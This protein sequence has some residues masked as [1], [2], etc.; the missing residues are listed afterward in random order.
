MDDDFDGYT[1]FPVDY[2]C[3]GKADMDEV[4]GMPAPACGDLVDNDADGQLDYSRDP[5]CDTNMD[6]DEFN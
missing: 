4:A 1:D 5:Q 2:G 3:D 6:P